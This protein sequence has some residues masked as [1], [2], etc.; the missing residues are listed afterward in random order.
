V[1]TC[2]E[3]FMF[4]TAFRAKIQAVFL[5]LTIVR[6]NINIVGKFAVSPDFDYIFVNC[7]CF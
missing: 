7:K 4:I 3:F 1:D 6:Q 2:Q 5:C